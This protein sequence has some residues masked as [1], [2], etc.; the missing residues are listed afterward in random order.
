MN[1]LKL[2]LAISKKE[3]VNF[4]NALTSLNEFSGELRTTD[5]IPDDVSE[6]LNCFSLN[7]P[8]YKI[9]EEI[10]YWEGDYFFHNFE[11]KWI[12]NEIVL[13]NK[14]KIPQ[15]LIKK[16][17]LA[18]KYDYAWNF[19]SI[20][21]F[22]RSSRGNELMLE[23][24]NDLKCSFYLAYEHY[25][26]QALQILRNYCEVSVSFLF[27]L[28]KKD[29]YDKWIRNKLDFYFP[30]FS[31]MLRYLFDRV[32]ILNNSEKKFLSKSYRTLNNSVHS[33]RHSLNMSINR[34]KKH[35]NSFCV[36]DLE[37]W[38]DTFI[39]LVKFMITLYLEK[40]FC[41]EFRG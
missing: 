18:T 24:A 16:Y 7:W 6:F 22:L 4:Q 29:E 40:F 38:C 13:E 39:S 1:L 35:V 15:K 20:F 28:A 31:E 23:S 26:K 25:F 14:I 30:E 17:V 21:F 19:L 41:E 3:F 5:K 11:E 37:E 27:F 10:L 36:E 34:L 8:E 33:K 12:N 9:P 32:K 2:N